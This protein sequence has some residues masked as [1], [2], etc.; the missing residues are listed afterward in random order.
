MANKFLI[1]DDDD[2]VRAF[3]C[4]IFEEEAEVLSARNGKEALVLVETHGFDIVICDVN[5]PLMNGIEFSKRAMA[6]NSDFVSHLI[7]ITGDASAEVQSFCSEHG[8][9]LLCKPF[10]VTMIRAAVKLFLLR[11]INSGE[12]KR[13]ARLSFDELLTGN[14]QQTAEMVLLAARLLLLQISNSQLLKREAG[15]SFEEVIAGSAE[16]GAEEEKLLLLSL[17]KTMLAC[18][19]ETH[20]RRD[21]ER[22]LFNRTHVSI[23]ALIFDVGS[24][25]SQFLTGTITDISF[26]GLRFSV[27]KGQATGMDPASESNE[28]NVF[29]GLPTVNQPIMI[30]CHPLWVR[31]PDGDVQVG[32]V[33]VLTDFIDPLT[34]QSRLS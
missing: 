24:A 18:H 17:I 15:K 28:F 9:L 2:T 30:K 16:K 3:L 26:G 13:E 31:D 12:F 19:M 33:S 4:A 21:K 20:K 1:V 5:M 7:M 25:T 23:P 27:A 32:A 10:S 22:R 34:A 29:F 11:F 14:V 8:I 6:V